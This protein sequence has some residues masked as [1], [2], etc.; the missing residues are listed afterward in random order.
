MIK[1]PAKYQAAMLLAQQEL[2]H[3]KR[4]EREK[5]EYSRGLT[6]TQ[7]LKAL[8][9]WRS[10]QKPVYK[11]VIYS[12]ALGSSALVLI[13]VSVILAVVLCPLL[14]AACFY[15]LHLR[16]E[17]AQQKYLATVNEHNLLLNQMQKNKRHLDV[18]AKDNYGNST[19]VR[20]DLNRIIKSQGWA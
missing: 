14:S 2:V 5:L 10:L 19:T 18:L 11:R 9:E 3:K 20:R 17:A 16:M 8:K 4:L 6:N 7:K 1:S 15:F 12:V 13:P